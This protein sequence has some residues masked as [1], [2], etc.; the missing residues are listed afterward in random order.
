MIFQA[1]HNIRQRGISLIELIIFIIVVSFFFIAATQLMKS[2][3]DQG[4]K[5]LINML[6]ANSAQTELKNIYLLD[7]QEIILGKKE[8]TIENEQIDLLIEARYAGEKFSLKKEKVKY[9]VVT[10]N[11]KQEMSITLSSYRFEY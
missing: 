3:T 11:Y 4:N 8:R 6:L 1:N 10:A 7:Y 2:I 9:I 5:P